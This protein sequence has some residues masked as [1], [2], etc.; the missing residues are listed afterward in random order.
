LKTFITEDFLLYNDTAREL[1]HETAKDLPIIDY[2]NHLDPYAILEDRKYKNLTEIW[3]GDHY[4]WRL[5]RANGI[6]EEYITG[7]RSDYDKFLA[8]A[9]TVPATLGS[10]LYHWS[11]ME[12]LRHFNIDVL[13]NEETAP[14]VWEEVN[15]KLESGEITPR[16]ILEKFKVEF[17]GTTDDPADPLD[18]HQKLREE[19]YGVFV[20]P[21]FRPDRALGIEKADFTAWVERLS[22][23]TNSNI[24]TYD[25]FLEA[26][27]R[28][29][30][31]F[32]SLGCRSSDHSLTVLFFAEAD[33]KE[34]S[35]IFKKRMDGERLTGKE[36]DQF[37]TYTLTR[38][39]AMYHKKDWAMQLHIGATRNNNTRMFRLLGPDSGYD[40]IA[41]PLCADKLARLLDGMEVSGQLPKTI[42]YS[43][44]ANDNNVLAAMAGNFQSGELPGKVQFGA[45]W[46][47]ND[48][49]SGIEDQLE[50]LANIG[51]LSAFVGMLTDSR[52]FLSLIRHEY[53]RRI[54]CNMLGSWVEEGKAPKD[55]K[56]LSTYVERI[57]YL[58]AKRYFSL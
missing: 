1:Y 29:V 16:K 11:H 8:W 32:D 37:K 27:E 33:L 46:W 9:K 5:M 44:N 50:T 57:C 31:F 26:L 54:L 30:D 35:E 25:K 15:R 18:A 19:G 41:N 3:L 22:K 58:N 28:R 34:V 6:G 38:L 17:V 7:E 52:S 49:L 40:S 51:L 42:L 4:K 21:S 36:V 23:V 39:A 13:L 43:L 53:F 20:A 55:M 14:F 2:H 24:D 10:P 48:S 47:F 56:L 45:A 12:L